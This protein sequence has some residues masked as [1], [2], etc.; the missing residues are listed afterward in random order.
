[1]NACAGID[2]GT[3]PVVGLGSVCR[4]QGSDE[5]GWIVTALADQFGLDNLHGFGVKA[6]GVAKY[7]A[8][9]A[10]SDSMA[11]SLDGRHVA[12]CAHGTRGKSEANCIAF[13]LEWR[14]RLLAQFNPWRQA[15]LAVL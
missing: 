14:E 15:G 7:G 1:M 2:L 4:R 6:L 8:A 5:I 9:L 12:G 11:W 3:E 13:G 10:S